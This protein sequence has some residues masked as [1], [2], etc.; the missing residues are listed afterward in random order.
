MPARLGAAAAIVAAATALA[1][2]CGGEKDF[3]A[4]EFVDSANAE[5]AELALGEQITTTPADEPVY[6]VRFAAPAGDDPN[7]QLQSGD[8][9]GTMV[10]AGD[11]TSAGDEFDHCESSADLTCFRAANVVLRFE[12]MAAS[13]RARVSGA[14]SALASDG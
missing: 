3:S 9:S 10:V 14:V 6:S 2:G 5:G 13:D 1:F 12:G 11:A 4:D 8:S 7:P